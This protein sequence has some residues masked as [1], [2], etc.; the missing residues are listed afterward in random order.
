MES[1]QFWYDRKNNITLTKENQVRSHDLKALTELLCILCMMER[2]EKEK[3]SI[4]IRK[5]RRRK[6]EHSGNN[7]KNDNKNT[8]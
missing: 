2:K 6:K 4:A 1:F 3:R 8:L 5:K 7:N